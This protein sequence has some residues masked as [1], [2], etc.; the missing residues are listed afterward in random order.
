MGFGRLC[1]EA[2]AHPR[3][4]ALNH[5]RLV[6]LALLG[7]TFTI[8]GCPPTGSTSGDD[9]DAT[10]D[11]DDATG[12]DADGD[13]F[14]S[15]EDCDDNNPG[16][17]P[18]ADEVCNGIDDDCD[19]AADNNPVDETTFFNDQDGDG[20]GNPENT[21]DACDQPI[22]FVDNDE[23][24]DDGDF[25]INPGEPE[26][27]DGVDTD[28]DGSVPADETDDDGDGFDECDGGD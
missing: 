22:G 9:D 3:E 13:G 6:L 23:D 15:D 16:V 5:I 14:D 12:E 21:F 26:V 2:S 18:D 8:T 20:Y 10:S 28:C 27:C 1:S 17:N 4:E 7:L 19:G 24:C 11:D 25:D